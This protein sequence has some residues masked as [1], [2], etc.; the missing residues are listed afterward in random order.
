M[1]LTIMMGVVHEDFYSKIGKEKIVSSLNFRGS[2][3]TGPMGGVMDGK[4]G[5]LPRLLHGVAPFSESA[6]NR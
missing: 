3:E 6:R 2:K 5:I 1:A 4:E